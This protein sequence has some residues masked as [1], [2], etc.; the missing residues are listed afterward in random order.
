MLVPAGTFLI[1]TI[2]LKS[3]VTLHIAASGK[4]LGSSDGKQYHAVDAIPLYRR[5][6]PRR[7]QLGA[8]LRR[9]RKERHPR[10]PRHHRR[11]GLSI[12]LA[13]SRHTSAQRTRRQQSSLSS[14]RLSL[15][16]P[17]RPQHR[18]LDCAFHSLR[19]IQSKRVHM[20]TIYIHNRV[21]GN[22]DG[23]HFISAQKLPSTTAPST[24]R[25]TP[26]PSSAVANSSLSP[27]SVFSTRWSVFRF[28]GGLPEHCHLQLRPLSRS[29]VAPSNS[30][31][32]P[33]RAT[34]TSLSRTSSSKM[35]PAP[36]T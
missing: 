25:T 1:G 20:D 29:T 10:R 11:P 12:P 17:H 31:A 22:N 13:R 19:I 6:N 4:L 24:L 33:D 2:E 27:T 26:A 16:G 14:A 36:S 21:N 30:R 28:G 35:S 8:P 3:N 9:Q 7:W 5:H 34:R 32:T 18:S 23:F 15:R